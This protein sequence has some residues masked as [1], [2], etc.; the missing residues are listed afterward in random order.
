VGFGD[1]DPF[2]HPAGYGFAPDGVVAAE[3]VLSSAALVTTLTAIARVKG[4]G[5]SGI[6]AQAHHIRAG[7]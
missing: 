2:A 1:C 7:D 4:H 3:A 6:G 5:F